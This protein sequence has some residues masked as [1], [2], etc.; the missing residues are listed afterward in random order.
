MSKGRNTRK[1]RQHKKKLYQQIREDLQLSGDL[2]TVP[3]GGLKPEAV[4]PSCQSRAALPSLVRQGLKEGWGT[5]DSAKPDIVAALL[6]PFYQDDVVLDENGQQVIVKPPRK[7][8]LQL[9]NALRVL[10]QTQWE[11]DHPVEA[12]KAK[13]ASNTNNTVNATVSVGDLFSDIDVI[14]QRVARVLEP[15]NTTTVSNVRANGDAEPMDEAQPHN[16]E[17]EPEAD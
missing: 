13:G 4:D 6:E 8:L 10:D 16:T 5:P 12:G 3:E 11:R 14:E 15:A 7:L 1:A 9:A 17:T 2:P